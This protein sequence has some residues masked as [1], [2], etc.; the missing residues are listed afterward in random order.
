MFQGSISLDDK[1]DLAAQ[2]AKRGNTHLFRNLFA[3][4]IH[5]IMPGHDDYV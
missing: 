4:P 5:V 1:D 2:T 3:D